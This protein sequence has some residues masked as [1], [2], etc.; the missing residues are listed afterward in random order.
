MNEAILPLILATLVATGIL[1]FFE[2]KIPIIPIISAVLVT[3]FG[4]LSLYFNDNFFLHKTN[5]CKYFIC[6]DIVYW[7][8]FS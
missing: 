3:V 2:K 5:Y 6:N 8:F 4:G 1:Y 7:K